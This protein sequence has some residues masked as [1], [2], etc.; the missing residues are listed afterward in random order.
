VKLIRCNDCGQPIALSHDWQNCEC[1][2]SGGAYLADGRRCFVAGPCSLY[3]IDNRLFYGMRVEAWP[4]Q[5]PGQT[6]DGRRKV[7]RLVDNPGVYPE[8]VPA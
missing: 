4:Y 1:G 5:E 7:I 8:R 3:G 6:R 2:R